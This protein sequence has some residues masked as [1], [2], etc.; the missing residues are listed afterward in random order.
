MILLFFD[1]RFNEY[2][3]LIIGFVRIDPYILFL[4][5]CRLNHIDFFEENKLIDI[6]DILTHRNRIAVFSFQICW[7]DNGY[8]IRIL[9][10]RMDDRKNYDV[11]HSMICYQKLIFFI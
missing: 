9:Y 4:D 3:F 2:F 5:N 6:I 8:E 11:D 1:I 10:F 7:Q